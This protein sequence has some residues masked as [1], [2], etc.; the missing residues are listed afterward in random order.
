[1]SFEVEAVYYFTI[2]VAIILLVELLIG[3]FALRKEPT[4]RG[5]MLGHAICLL[6]AFACIV[7]LIYG[8]H[9]APDG[10]TYNGSGLLALIGILWFVAECFIINVLTKRQ[11]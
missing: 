11:K 4:A 5:A 9:V 3:V 6:L 2:G 7:Y 10:G 8:N 1:M